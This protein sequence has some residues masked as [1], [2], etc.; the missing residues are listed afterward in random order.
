MPVKIK[1]S[2]HAAV[3]ELLKADAVRWEG[4]EVSIGM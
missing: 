1:M 3:D 4:N 2:N